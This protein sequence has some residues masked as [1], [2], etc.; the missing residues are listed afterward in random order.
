MKIDLLS[1][2]FAKLVDMVSA[3]SNDAHI[4]CVN[5]RIRTCVPAQ[6]TTVSPWRWMEMWRY[7]PAKP[8]FSGAMNLKSSYVPGTLSAICWPLGEF[9]SGLKQTSV[10]VG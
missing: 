4:Q 3:H 9:P 6:I 5:K 7:R 1:F 8:Q 2:V 10:H